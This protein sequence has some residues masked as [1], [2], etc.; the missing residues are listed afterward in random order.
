MITFAVSQR[1]LEAAGLYP[2]AE[3]QLF[4]GM[5]ETFTSTEMP[6]LTM[7]FAYIFPKA[8]S[9]S[10]P[11]SLNFSIVQIYHFLYDVMP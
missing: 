9:I 4:A 1:M 5:H 2:A 11:K 3:F 8:K 10:R 6:K 7:T